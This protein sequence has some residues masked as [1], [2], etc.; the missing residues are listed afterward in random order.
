MSKNL[1]VLCVCFLLK[2]CVGKN[3]LF[4]KVPSACA[5]KLLTSSVF[6]F[7]FQLPIR[8]QHKFSSQKWSSL[9]AHHLLLG[10]HNGP[11]VSCGRWT[12]STP[13]EWVDRPLHFHLSEMAVG[14]FGGIWLSFI[15]KCLGLRWVWPDIWQWIWPVD[16]RFSW[17][18]VHVCPD[19]P[20]HMSA[21]H[22]RKKAWVYQLPIQTA[23]RWD[24]PFRHTLHSLLQLF[25]CVLCF[26]FCCCSPS[27]SCFNILC[28]Q[29]CSSADL[30]C[31]NLI[32]CCLLKLERFSS[33][34]WHQQG[35]FAHRT[36]TYWIFYVFQAIHCKP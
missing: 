9:R 27:S 25:L 1:N 32:C 31:N 15:Q 13:C 23:G 24:A 8:N 21:V 30:G 6:S 4:L 35:I 19:P 18:E 28:V 29:R 17:R 34:L 10:E 36:A 26:V 16:G 11:S 2:V 12:A 33:D 3:F 20:S 22:P 5:F 7:S 14:C